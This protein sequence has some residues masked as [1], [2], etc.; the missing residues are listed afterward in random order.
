[1]Q[2]EEEEKQR[3]I[4]EERLEREMKLREA[5]AER[6]AA[7]ERKALEAVIKHFLQLNDQTFDFTA[8]LFNGIS[9]V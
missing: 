1:M 7:E 5:E 4:E 3:L 8:F 2:L 6:I 9:S